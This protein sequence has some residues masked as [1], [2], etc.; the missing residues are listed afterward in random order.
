[1]EDHDIPGNRMIMARFLVS[2]TM[3]ITLSIL[4][5]I[6]TIVVLIFMGFGKKFNDDNSGAEI[7]FI[8]IEFLLLSVFLVD[9]VGR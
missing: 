6:Y 1:L 7:S 2:K 8:V 3:D 4:I 9:I 5:A